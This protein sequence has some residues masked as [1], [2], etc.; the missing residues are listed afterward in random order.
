MLTPDFFLSLSTLGFLS[1]D[2]VCHSFDNKANGYGRGE[3]FCVIVIKP[4][5]AALHD[6]DN[7]RAI[8]RA[9]GVN[10]N[11]LTTLAHPSKELQFQLIEDTYRK[12]KLDKSR[13]GFFEAHGTGTA[14]GDPLE[15]MAIAN[16]FSPGRRTSEPLIM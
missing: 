16:A 1:P 11:G 14:V 15:A 3:G 8:I 13:T 10:Q 4:V 6:G 12:A 2:G 9:S 5:D 7:I